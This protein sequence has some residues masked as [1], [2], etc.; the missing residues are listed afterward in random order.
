MNAKTV[1]PL[2]TGD[3]CSLQRRRI[4]QIDAA[5]H[6]SVL[7][8]CLSLKD[9]YAVVRRA[10]CQLSPALTAYQ[11]HSQVV[12]IMAT[13]NELSKLID[14][15]LEKRHAVAART[16]RLA[17]TEAELEARWKEA[18]TRGQITGAYW[19][20]LSHPL[21]SKNLQWQVF[22]DVHMLSHL[23]GASRQA[24]LCRVH[25][26]EGAHAVL[27]GKLAQLKHDH[28]SVLKDCRRLEDEVATRR[29]DVERTERRLLTAQSTI[30]ALESGSLATERLARISEL[31]L[32]LEQAQARA[33][34]ADASACEALRLLEEA[35]RASALAAEHALELSAENH[36][37]E[38]ELTKGSIG[39][40]LAQGEATCDDGD[41]ESLCGKRIL[42]LGGRRNLVQ[43]YRML[44]ERRGGEFLYH[45]GGLEESLDA[46]TRALVTVDAVICPVDCVSHAAC[47]N[48]K[49]AC[50]N[51]AKRF[52]P[53]RSA[54][55]SSFARGIQTIA[56]ARLSSSARL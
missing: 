6:C 11:L 52:V 36:A 21:C 22:G 7:G 8:T 14:K 17:T 38:I 54:G 1:V 10:G 25:E 27:D 3:L 47:L 45:D 28:R 44:V 30:A 2:G 19:G 40:P 35:R 46:A 20:V 9:L 43:H 4:W 55:L 42:C 13:P 48:V 53:L 56:G 32:A 33:S 23:V 50:K 29:R 34:A 26:L 15:E 51:L 41:L 49:R 16:V 24:D 31:S 12:D 5:M 37:L 18:A 39:C